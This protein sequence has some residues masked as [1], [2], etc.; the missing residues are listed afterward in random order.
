MM[1]SNALLELA[2]ERSRDLIDDARRS[3]RHLG[4]R[5]DRNLPASELIF[6][7][8]NSAHDIDARVHAAAR[9]RVTSGTTDR[10]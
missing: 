9:L 4:R 3:R 6:L 8:G 1:N 2:R 10:P 5:E 7:L